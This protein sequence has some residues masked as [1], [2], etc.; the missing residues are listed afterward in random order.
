[1]RWVDRVGAALTPERKRTT[2]AETARKARQPT[3][4]MARQP[5]AATPTVAHAVYLSS[6]VK[7]L[8]IATAPAVRL[9]LKPVLA[10]YLKDRPHFQIGVVANVPPPRRVDPVLVGDVMLF[11][12]DGHAMYLAANPVG[13]GTSATTRSEEVD[14]TVRTTGGDATVSCTVLPA[15]GP[16]EVATRRDAWV[17]A[18]GSA[19]HTAQGWR[20][21]PLNLRSVRASLTLP[22]DHVVRDPTSSAGSDT[23]DGVFVVELTARGAQAWEQALTEGQPQDL[24]GSVQFEVSYAAELDG[25]LRTQQHTVSGALGDVASGAPVDHRTVRAEVGVPARL[26]VRGHPTIDRVAITLHAG[27]DVETAVI[28]PDGGEVTMTLATTQTAVEEI[29][30]SAEV[31]FTSAAWPTIATSGVLSDARGWSAILA[32][33]T[34]TRT[35]DVMTVLVDAAGRTVTPDGAEVVS[36]SLRYR[37]ADPLGRTLHTSFEGRHQQMSAVVVPDPPTSPETGT[38]SVE[39]SMMVLRGDRQSMSSTE[40]GPDDRWVLARV[41]PDASVDFSTNTTPGSERDPLRE[42][43]L[44]L[45]ELFG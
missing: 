30:W 35:I 43:R 40:I 13:I 24:V 11:P 36:G 34:W 3:V 37:P 26:L 9:P 45:Q 23:A 27:D 1:M 14:G 20:F 18:L 10:S 31:A 2:E 25:E 41:R 16:A 19:G 22:A 4:A 7:Q 8:R 28:G 33:A 44:A 38:A 6:P 17:A 32:P 12:G 42:T 5:L 15:L 21:Q 29:R 39:L